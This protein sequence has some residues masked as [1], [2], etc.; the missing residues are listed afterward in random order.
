MGIDFDDVKNAVS[1]ENVDQAAEFAKSRFGEHAD[2]ID[3]AAD[4][5]KSF[6]DRGQPGER[7][8][9]NT[10]SGESDHRQGNE[11]GGRE[12][13][14]Y[15]RS[16]GTEYGG[17]RQPGGD[18]GRHATAEHDNSSFAEEPRAE[19]AATGGY[20][21]SSYDTGNAGSGYRD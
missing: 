18:Y 1:G 14:G 10:P 4:K 17:N 2:K 15:D 3:A 7:D 16:P 9:D 8:T 20:G 13:G 21:E 12:D 6:F 5:A 11:Y 19:E